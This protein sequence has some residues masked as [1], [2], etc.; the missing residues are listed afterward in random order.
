MNIN[1]EIIERRMADFAAR[2]L[3]CAETVLYIVCEHLGETGDFYPRI[4]TPFGGGIGNRQEMC[5]ALSGALM[6]IGLL[7]GR[8]LGGDRFPSYNAATDFVT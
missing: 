4:A 7:R 3:N 5:G 8:S 2:R 1:E 6:A